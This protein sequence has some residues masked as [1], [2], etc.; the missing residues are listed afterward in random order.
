MRKFLLAAALIVT[1]AS[2][3][4]PSKLAAL[5]WITGA[6]MAQDGE[7][8]I[9]ERWLGPYGDLMLGVS[10]TANNGSAVAFEY[11]RIEAKDGAITYL[12]QPGGRPPT[13]F[14]LV[15]HEPGLAVFENLEHDFPQRIIYRLIDKDHLTA[16]VESAGGEGMD[17]AYTRAP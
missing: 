12:A 7:N 1:A 9:E 6:W 5:D 17:F 2:A 8:T 13:A 10:L 3:A 4:E 14:K 15:K 16:R 11:L